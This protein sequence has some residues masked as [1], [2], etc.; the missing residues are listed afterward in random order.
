MDDNKKNRF[1]G[2]LTPRK[3]LEKIRKG[4]SCVGGVVVAYYLLE[5]LCA[6]QNV[7]MN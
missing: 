1:M 3:L 2:K 7:F 6:V 5:E 4:L